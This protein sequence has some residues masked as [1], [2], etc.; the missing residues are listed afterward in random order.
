[1]CQ[2]RETSIPKALR[3]LLI[4]LGTTV[5]CLG[6]PATAQSQTASTGALAVVA[7]DASGGVV[8]DVL[9]T[10]FNQ[11]TGETQSTIS[12]KDGLLAFP[13][14]QLGSRDF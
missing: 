9:V 12:D 5:V 10:V 6:L 1:M 14:S 2:P 7:L 3:D 11:A 13:S 4:W 8:P